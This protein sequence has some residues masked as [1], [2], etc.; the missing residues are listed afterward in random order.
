MLEIKCPY[1]GKRSQNEFSYGGDATVKR[2]TLGEEISTEDWDNFVYF[3]D[4]ATHEIFD[5]CKM[6]EA[7]NE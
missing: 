5:T 7:F 3:R 1:C 4:T 2:P 6:N